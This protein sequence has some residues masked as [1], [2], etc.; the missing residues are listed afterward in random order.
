[1][2]R[3][4]IYDDFERKADA[5]WADIKSTPLDEVS[6][7]IEAS[8]SRVAD[9]LTCDAA[10]T[11]EVTEERLSEPV[12]YL[13]RLAF[14][15]LEVYLGTDIDLV[16]QA[17]GNALTAATAR[18]MPAG[19]K[20]KLARYDSI[21]ADVLYYPSGTNWQDVVQ[22]GLYDDIEP[23]GMDHSQQS[24]NSMTVD[25]PDSHV[26]VQ[27]SLINRTYG[28]D[29]NRALNFQKRFPK[30]YVSDQLFAL[31]LKDGKID[32]EATERA[33]EVATRMPNHE[34]V[35]NDVD[36]VKGSSAYFMDI[37]GGIVNAAT[38]LEVRRPILQKHQY[39][40][41]NPNAIRVAVS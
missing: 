29:E 27:D 2:S 38:E 20:P 11:F 24:S 26:Y 41:H 37:I 19:K 28:V 35:T 8:Y 7:D 5:V 15:K 14:V 23:L 32:L 31:I 13:A 22:Y 6:L 40:Y 17:R 18:D 36:V 16:L 34:V 25:C 33:I 30:P 10:Q 4:P 1:M 21:R 3:H 9:F 12:T 39:F